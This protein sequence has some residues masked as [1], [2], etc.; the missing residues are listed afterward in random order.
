MIHQIQ[1]ELAKY[2]KEQIIAFM[3]AIAAALIAV[4]ALLGTIITVICTALQGCLA[5]RA[6]RERHIRELTVNAA[7]EQWK[8]ERS[9]ADARNE[10]GTVKSLRLRIASFLKFSEVLCEK[11]MTPEAISRNIIASDEIVAEAERIMK[12]VK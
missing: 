2:S 8:T 7:I 9:R 3:P 6:E 4:G 10:T 5:S 1:T 12:N 11:S